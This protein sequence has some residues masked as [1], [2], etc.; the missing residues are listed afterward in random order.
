MKTKHR[1]GAPYCCLANRVSELEC[2]LEALVLE[3]KSHEC[4]FRYFSWSEKELAR[5]DKESV[6]LREAN[7]QLREVNVQLREANVQLR[8]ANVQQRKVNDALQVRLLEYNLMFYPL[9]TDADFN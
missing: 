9:P 8:E 4:E 7:V 5:K 6:K 2:T 3:R 1:K